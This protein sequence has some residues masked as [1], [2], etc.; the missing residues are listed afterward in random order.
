M[1]EETLENSHPTEK[2]KIEPI[3]GRVP[4]A[5]ELNR[6]E[7]AH[8]V[9]EAIEK[10]ETS[11]HEGTD[12]D[13]YTEKQSR[14]KSHRSPSETPNAKAEGDATKPHR[15]RKP[16]SRADRQSKVERSRNMIQKKNDPEEH[17]SK[18]RREYRNYDEM[19]ACVN[20]LKY[21]D[22]EKIDPRVHK[23]SPCRL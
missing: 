6:L 2:M 4:V 8:P 22:W 23:N 3:Q 12:S 20:L 10:E 13:L 9:N 5:E 11:L 1:E 16:R 17:N 21:M 7:D 15:K 14:S 18:Y 19:V